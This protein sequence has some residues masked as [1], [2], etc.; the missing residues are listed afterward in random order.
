MLSKQ[1]IILSSIREL[2]LQSELAPP[3][4]ERQKTTENQKQKSLKHF[5]V[6]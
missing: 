1:K 4:L 5:A 3:K 2:Q 6:V